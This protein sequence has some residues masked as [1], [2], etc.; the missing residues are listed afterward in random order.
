MYC[1]WRSIFTIKKT[2]SV[3][4]THFS[5][6]CGNLKENYLILIFAR[7]QKRI[8]SSSKTTPWPNAPWQAVE[9]QLVKPQIYSSCFSSALD[10]FTSSQTGNQVM[11]SPAE[12]RVTLQEV[13]R[14]PPQ[15]TLCLQQKWV[16]VRRCAV[17]AVAHI[18]FLGFTMVSDEFHCHC[19]PSKDVHWT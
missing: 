17:I 1:C 3:F 12:W 6:A 7:I 18:L 9:E 4:S 19:E 5:L 16:K 2:L 15:I 13:G 8:D 14:L 11:L 10:N